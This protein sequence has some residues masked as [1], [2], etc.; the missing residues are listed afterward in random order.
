MHAY[1]K[2]SKCTEK[3][4]VKRYSPSPYSSFSQVNSFLCIFLKT[5]AYV[6]IYTLK[7]HTYVHIYVYMFTYIIHVHIYNIYNI[8]IKL[9]YNFNYTLKLMYNFNYT[10]KLM[11]NFN[12]ILKTAFVQPDFIIWQSRKLNTGAGLPPP[13]WEICSLSLSASKQKKIMK[14]F[15][16]LPYKLFITKKGQVFLLNRVLK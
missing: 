7:L 2:K 12:Y 15:S 16:P 3:Y 13:N 14:T 5:Y 9:M 4:E 10:L 11:Y 6:W 1:S 8:Y